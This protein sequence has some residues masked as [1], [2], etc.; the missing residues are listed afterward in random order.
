MRSHNQEINQT[1]LEN[2]M[3]D[4]EKRGIYMSLKA[5]SYQGNRG[6]MIL[7]AHK[8]SL[9]KSSQFR[10]LGRLRLSSHKA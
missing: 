7:R 8:R 6:H 5:H 3:G 9:H 1:H 4:H 2:Q 10:D